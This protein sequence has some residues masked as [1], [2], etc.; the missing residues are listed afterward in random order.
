MDKG[1]GFRE[2]DWPRVIE[3]SDVDFAADFYDPLLSEAIEYKRGVGYFTTGWLESA[4]RGIVGLAANAGTA[5]WIASPILSEDD[6]EAIETGEAARSDPQL[7]EALRSS[8]E[9]LAHELETDTRNAIAWMI[10]DGLLE[11]KFAIPDGKLHGQFH[12][13]FGIARD[14]EGNR[15]AFHGSQND[16]QNAFENYEAYTVD[17]DW[18]SDRE[19]EAVGM[20]EARFDALWNNEK[21]NVTTFTLPET[22]ANQLQQLRTT[23]QRPYPRP[24]SKKPE[25]DDEDEGITL[26]N[27]QQQAVDNWVENGR[28]GL[29]EMATGTGKTYTAIGA[30]RDLLDEYRARDDTLVVVITVP[31]THL[32]KQWADSLADFGYNS[33][34]LLYGSYDTE[35]KG[36]LST[37]L[38]DVELGF[39]E[40][41]III[42]THATGSHEFFRERLK[43]LDCDALVIAD[44]V[45]NLGAEHQRKGLVPQFDYRLGLSATPERFYDEEGTDFLFRYFD[46]TVF[47]FTLKDAIPEYLT[48][49]EYYPRVVE[50]DEEELERYRSISRKIARLSNSESPDIEETRER[51]LNKRANILKSARRK[52]DEL[53][54]ILD[55]IEIDHLLVYT[56]YEQIDE[57]QERMAD[58]G[59]VQHRFTAEEND[60]ERQQLLNA[61][62]DGS[63]EALV[64]MK[65]LDEG[66]DVPSTRQAIL[67]ANSRNPKEFV[68]RRGRV[69]RQHPE[70]G[71]EKA[72]IYDMVV[73][74]TTDPDADLVASEKGILERELDRFEEFAATA[75][76][77]DR[78]RLAL[79]D[80]RREFGV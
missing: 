55:E 41:E 8:I 68:Q 19:A 69:L 3:T 59:I 72:I 77:E 35:W 13:K 39:S 40:Q 60:E 45:H 57:V 10:A 4:A 9:S 1:A 30:M 2:K 31:M 80:L 48:P 17:C 43:Q 53:E 7:K 74:P 23:D 50:M 52:Y 54:A 46:E 44:E 73:V 61:F 58:R 49:Y 56:N 28:H 5:R 27:Y 76:N 6:W 67:M 22:I 79:Q 75:L 64:A 62:A 12:D 70:S 26:R 20:H 51:L 36:K 29:F 37:L 14:K 38:D 42:T 24:P 18:V 47:E 66:V 21:P 15:I 16:S 33:P 71:K 11:L 25:D 78:A 63:Y 34:R 32:A 65:C